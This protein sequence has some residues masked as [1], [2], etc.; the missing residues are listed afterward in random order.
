MYKRRYS[1][2]PAVCSRISCMSSLSFPLLPQNGGTYRITF[3]FRERE[4]HLL[5]ICPIFRLQRESCGVPICYWP[6][7]S[8]LRLRKRCHLCTRTQDSRYIHTAA[9][10]KRRKRRSD[11]AAITYHPEVW[12][13]AWSNFA[14][15]IRRGIF[16]LTWS[17]MTDTSVCD[18]HKSVTTLHC[19]PSHLTNS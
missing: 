16:L 13:I 9:R 17:T 1:Q 4:A 7:A 10:K 3:L 18:H 14:F 5:Q 2:I 11:T 12:G 19:D 8:R 6:R 15:I